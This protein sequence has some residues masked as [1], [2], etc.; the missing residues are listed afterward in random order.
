[1]CS[2]GA[3]GLHQSH[4]DPLICKPKM[5]LPCMAAPRAAASAVRLHPPG[6]RAGGLA[7]AEGGPHLRR[8]PALAGEQAHDRPMPWV[9]LSVTS[10]VV[11]VGLS[12]PH[13]SCKESLERDEVVACPMWW[14]VPCTIADAL[15]VPPLMLA[16]VCSPSY[17]VPTYL[18]SS[19][20]CSPSW[21]FRAARTGGCSRSCRHVMCVL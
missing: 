12:T 14:P 6:G 11:A 15:F 21:G 17:V 1:M 4:D 19:M 3:G 10:L 7:D 13:A 8:A 2:R 9:W 5:R 16:P 18:R 20:T